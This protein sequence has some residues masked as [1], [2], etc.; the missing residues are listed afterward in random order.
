MFFSR[1]V[2]VAISFAISVLATPHA[3]NH[4]PHHRAIAARVAPNNNHTALHRRQSSPRCRQRLTSS[5]V[6]A[7]SSYTPASP[8]YTPTPPSPIV[9]ATH[10]KP[11][12]PVSS[13]TPPA[14]TTT[15]PGSS[16][17]DPSFMSGVQTGGD[18]TFYSGSSISLC[19]SFLL[20]F[21][22]VTSWLG[23]LWQYKY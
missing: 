16:S 22:I 2:L 3:L 23:C 13:Y 20:N 19:F 10:T 12:S 5:Y 11:P 9:S 14:P 21:Q 1:A 8:S 15:A 17:G 4:V 18:G 6:P 7:S